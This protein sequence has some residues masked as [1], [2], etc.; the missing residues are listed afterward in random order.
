MD[1]EAFFRALGRDK[2]KSAGNI[3]YI[4]PGSQSACP[5]TAAEESLVKKI[6]NGVLKF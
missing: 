6:I 1:E 4:V 2:K 5:V 3:L